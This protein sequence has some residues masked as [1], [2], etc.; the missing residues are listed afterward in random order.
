MVIGAIRPGKAGRANQIGSLLMG[1]P[2]ADG[3]QYV[4][5]V[6]SGFSDAELRRLAGLLTPLRT[7]DS[8]FLEVPRAD[9]SDALWVLPHVVA[10]VAM[11]AMA[12]A[13]STDGSSRVNNA[14]NASAASVATNRV[15]S[16]SRRSPGSSSAR[17]NATF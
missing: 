11:A 16:D 17:T 8:P 3:L 13:L 5:R 9:A 2:T 14:K 7:N 15:R 12:V 1:I 10:E 4:G 6:G